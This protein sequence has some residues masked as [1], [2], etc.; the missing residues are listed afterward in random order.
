MTKRRKMMIKTLYL[1]LVSITITTSIQNVSGKLDI[2]GETTSWFNDDTFNIAGEIRNN[3]SRDVDFVKIS[4]TLYN[5]D[6]T[7]IGSDFTYMDPST[8]PAG[9]TSPFQF[10]ITDFNVR[11][12]GEINTYKLTVSGD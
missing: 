10:R 11:N 8:I 6:G 7:V 4:A 9:D 3:G 2:L 12:V 1:L 5:S